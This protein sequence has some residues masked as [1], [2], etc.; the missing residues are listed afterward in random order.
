[1]F[2]PTTGLSFD[3]SKALNT[4]YQQ[5]K[6]RREKK[7]MAPLFDL[8][9][10]YSSLNINSYCRS[11]YFCTTCRF[12][13]KLQ[14]VT[15]LVSS[16]GEWRFPNKINFLSSVYQNLNIRLVAVK[17]ILFNCNCPHEIVQRSHPCSH[18]VCVPLLFCQIQ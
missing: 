14:I 5:Q 10:R 3:V 11:V 13:I 9:A 6:N 1:M 17:P 16:R 18:I 8:L 2:Y 15:A 4:V 7:T 12:F